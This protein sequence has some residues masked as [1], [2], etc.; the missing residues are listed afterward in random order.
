MG[1]TKEKQ[2]ESWR[3]KYNE[4]K[5]LKAIKLSWSILSKWSTGRAYDQKEALQMLLARDAEREETD[6]MK[7]GSRIHKKI[8]LK[9]MKLLPMMSDNVIFEGDRELGDFTNYFRVGVF[10]WLDMSLIVDA[11]DYENK[12][13]IDWKTGSRNSTQHNKMQL[14]VYAYLMTK[15]QD[16]PLVP[17]NAIL[18]KVYEDTSGAIICSDFSMYSIDENKLTV[19]ENYIET[20]A[21]E[22][23]NFLEENRRGTTKN[24]E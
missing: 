7:E 17:E 10:D 18:A 9:Q 19:A 21:S 6:A 1:K 13:I 14:Y 8:A 16:N 12:L 3:F 5:S 4:D 2:Y 23:F 11:I 15:L 20:N 22:I 24:M